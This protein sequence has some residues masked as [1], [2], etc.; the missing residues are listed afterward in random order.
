MHIRTLFLVAMGILIAPAAHATMVLNITGVGGSGETTWTFSGSATAGNA[1]TLD[2]DDDNN[3]NDQGDT[4]VNG[5]HWDLGEFTVAN[6]DDF[7]VIGS[8]RTG[9]LTIGSVTK[10]IY[11]AYI[12]TDTGF[13]DISVGV[14]GGGNYEFNLG[15]VVSW[16]GSMVVAVDI[17]D[18]VQGSY[19]TSRYGATNGA[20][21]VQVNIVPEPTTAGLML[22]GLG[23]LAMFDRRSRS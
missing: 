10:E 21:D 8:S 11:Y 12:D 20:L 4:D 3:I 2:F 6:L 16:T 1:S 7:Q 19:T 17:D 13:D 23:G 5:S 22:L 9:M 15:D 18:L 14:N